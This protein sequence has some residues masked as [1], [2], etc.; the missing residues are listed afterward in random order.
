VHALLERG[1]EGVDLLLAA[2]GFELDATVG[3][4]AD[5]AGDVEAPGHLHRGEAEADALHAPGEENGFVMHV[6][7]SSREGYARGVA[8]FNSQTL[9]IVAVVYDCRQAGF[10]FAFLGHAYSVSAQQPMS[11]FDSDGGSENE[12]EERGDLAWNEFDWE[13]YLREQDES[14]IRYLRFYEASQSK[15]DRID[16][17]A[18]LMGWGDGE[19]TD[20]DSAEETASAKSEDADF[21]EDDEDEVYT[22]HKN[23]IFISTKAICLSL[24]KRWELTAADNARVPQSLAISFL[25][26]LHRQEENAVHAIHALDFGDYAM[27]VSLFKRALGGLN[28]SL[29]LLNDDSAM[30][31]R[32]VAAYREEALPRLFDLR[33]IWLRVI[34][35]CREELNRPVDDE[36]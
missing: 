21:G 3:E 36:N 30:K 11:N 15:T 16:E 26:S 5:V 33:E 22:L 20:D 10:L 17:V 13:R 35:E 25:A 7:H 29:A 14:V 1:D 12:W 18:E 31:H 23:P 34:T 28:G 24:K 6:G 9:V 8:A 2:L 19:W 32:A 27:A 4:I